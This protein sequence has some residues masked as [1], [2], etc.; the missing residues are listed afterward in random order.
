MTSPTPAPELSPLKRAFVALEEMKAKL[1]AAERRRNEPIAIIGMGCRFPAGANSP[2]Q[3]WELLRSGV[4]A[5]AEIPMSRWDV[6]AYYDADPDAVG[7]MYTRWAGLLDQVDQFEPQFFGISPREA[8]RMDPQQRLVLEVAWEALEAAAQ[9]PDK[10]QNSS[11]GVFLGLCTSDYAN[12]QANS[13]SASEPDAYTLS[14]LA[15]SIAAGRLSYVLGLHGPSV[16]IDTACS[17]ALVAVH[18]A[19]QSLRAEDCRMALAGGVHLILS[20]ENSVNFSRL[21]ML[22]ADGRCKTFD[23]D[24]DGFVEGEGCGVVVLKRLSDALADQDRIVGVIRGSAVN[25]DG[26]SSGLTA[27]NGPA[28]EAVM[29]TALSRAGLTGSEIDYVEAHGTGTSLGDPIELQALGAALGGGRPADRPLLVGSVKTNLG[30]LQAAA[31][32]AG[33]VKILLSLEREELPAHLHFATPNPYVPWDRLPLRVLTERVPWRAGSRPRIAGISAFGFSGT[34]AHLI[35]EEA[36]PVIRVDAERERPLHVLTLSARSASILVALASRWRDRLRAAA[37][38]D[39]PDLCFTANA[40]RAH[41]PHRVAMTVASLDDAVDQLGSIVEGPPSVRLAR[42]H[43]ASSDR[44]Q[45]A[46][47]FTG[48]GSQRVGMGRQLYETQ[49]TFRA[50]LDRCDAMLRSHLERPL[51]SVLYPERAD[52]RRIDETSYTQPALFAIEYALAEMWRSWGVVPGAVLGHSVGEYVAATLAGVFD[53][54]Q[55][56]TLVAARGRLMQSL[57]AGGAMAAVLAGESTVRAALAAHRGKVGIAAVNGPGNVVISGAADAVTAVIER[58]ES[59]GVVT[60][61]LTVSHAFHSSLMD[62]ILDDFERAAGAARPSA[63][64]MLLISNLTGKPVRR[65]VAEAGYWRRH[66]REPVLFA[67]GIAS[68][69]DQGYRTFVEIGPRPT[70]CGMGQRSIGATDAAWLPSL[71]PGREDWVQVLDAVRELYVRGAAIDWNGFD[72]DYPRRKRLAPTYPFDRARYWIPKDV[73]PQA[74]L[75]A[76]PAGGHPL[77]G[78][79]VR[80]ALGPVIFESTISIAAVPFLADHQ[81]QGRALF[82]ATAYLEM[83]ITAAQEALGVGDYVFEDLVISEPLALGAE[84]VTLQVI[85]SSAAG[86]ASEVRFYSRLGARPGTDPWRTHA[87]GTARPAATEPATEAG[88]LED[89]RARCASPMSVDD[90]YAALLEAGHFWGPAFRGVSALWAGDREALARIEL[91]ALVRDE[92]ASYRVHPVLLDSAMQI[93]GAAVPEALRLALRRETFLPVGLGRYRIYAD[94]RAAGWSHVRLRDLDSDGF[95]AD[96]RLYDDDGR[97]VAEVVD[98]YNRRMPV[99]ARSGTA[100][101]MCELAWRLTARVAPAGAAVKTDGT[102]LIVGQPG[103]IATG[104]VRRFTD[105][106]VRAI[107]VETAGRYEPLNDQAHGAVD[108]FDAEHF[109]RL[110]NQLRAVQHFRIEGAVHLAGAGFAAGEPDT[111]SVERSVRAECAALLHLIQALG[112]DERPETQRLCLVTCGAVAVADVSADVAVAQAPLWGLMRTAAI[113]HE[114]LRCTSVDLDPHAPEDDL[115]RLS[116]EILSPDRENQVAFRG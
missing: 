65:E 2:E 60:E 40:G 81:K 96:V 31:G 115:D 88:S 38:A 105:Q 64:T 8:V 15:H 58:L 70:L 77:L 63:A 73:E 6:D 37:D 3:F 30:H 49:P 25:H 36:P 44:Q 7:R 85:V 82:P 108:A 68:L 39:L 50:A 79:A 43:L 46:F 17:S 35:V 45:I 87:T 53:L 84:S 9:P 10:L 28:Q 51:L 69:Y 16:A 106:G 92:A 113:E 97:L 33:L 22:A 75:R 23:A 61:R 110:L 99:D 14:G 41:L 52:D 67:S 5:V 116:A 71:R 4:S 100:P 42:G 109:V 27:P 66:L 114:E 104:L 89:V 59:T 54:E 26:P 91:P 80:T 13:L 72:R 94:G 62:P 83:G 103:P 11:T 101:T 57:P 47:L 19:C 95:V 98:I 20:P 90:F 76:Q 78:A 24:A 56:L 32:L 34:N 18:L 29:R 1:E 107:V 21:R 55:A 111:G 74:R 93:M 112:G 48:Q 12:L 102:W 86:D